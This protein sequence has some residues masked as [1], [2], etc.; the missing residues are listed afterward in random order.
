[1]QDKS[2]LVKIY[3]DTKLDMNLLNVLMKARQVSAEMESHLESTLTSFTG[4]HAMKILVVPRER[5]S[6]ISDHSR[7]TSRLTLTPSAA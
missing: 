3:T 1:M 5:N 6:Q 7:Q 4:I 2:K